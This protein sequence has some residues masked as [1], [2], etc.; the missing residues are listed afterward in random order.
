MRYFF[1]AGKASFSRLFLKF[2]S[3]RKSVDLYRLGY[4]FK[5]GFTGMG[6]NTLF[7][8]SV[9]ILMGIG[10]IAFIRNK[11]KRERDPYATLVF[12]TA[13]G[14]VMSMVVC[15]KLYEIAYLLVDKNI[16]GIIR[17]FIVIAP[18]EEAAKLFTLFVIYRFLHNKISGPV[19]SM[20]FMACIALGF[21]LIENFFYASQ[22]PESAYLIFVRLFISTPMHMT[23][24][25]LMGL[26]FY[27]WYHRRHRY[28]LLV[29]S[30]VYGSLVHG[31]FDA[32]IFMDN[33][34][35]GIAP[36]AI[37]VSSIC[38]GFIAINF[39]TALSP[40]RPSL[41]EFI[42][43]TKKP[44]LVKGITCDHCGDEKEKFLYKNKHFMLH[45]CNSCTKIL[46]SPEMMKGFLFYFTSNLLELI[47]AKQCF[48]NRSN[49]NDYDLEE[50]HQLTKKLRKRHIETYTGRWLPKRWFYPPIKRIS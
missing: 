2:I 22:T 1:L 27:V 19:D 38:V 39:G 14:G 34:W 18:V 45:R 3:Y 33:N 50:L 23:Y 29:A 20:I 13:L 10:C 44:V 6:N 32:F 43:S 48:S 37:L 40:L 26:G 5:A 12:V 9:S 11:D 24:S 41:K 17:S 15:L 4:G 42:V 46:I 16:S 28:G 35:H 21:S 30:F 47:A 36:I 7:L 31:L 25:I 8:I 49:K